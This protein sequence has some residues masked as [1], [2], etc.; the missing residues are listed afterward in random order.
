M[1]LSQRSIDHEDPRSTVR[2][3]TEYLNQLIMDN[4]KLKG[5]LEAREKEV[6]WLQNELGKKHQESENIR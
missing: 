4:C 3:L 6:R 5:E 1:Q 2:Y